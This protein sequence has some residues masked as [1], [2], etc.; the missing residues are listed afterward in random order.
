[1]TPSGIE[2]E[3]FRFVAQHLNHCAT[4]TPR[5]QVLDKTHK[6]Y[7][8]SPLLSATVMAS[9]VSHTRTFIRIDSTCI[10]TYC[11]L[12]CLYCLFVL[13]LLHTFILI[14]FVC[15]SVRT[16]ATEWK[17]NCS[18]STTTTTTT[19]N[20]NNNNNNRVKLCTKNRP[21]ELPALNGRN[22]EELHTI[23]VYLQ[24]CTA[25]CPLGP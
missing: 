20:N 3:T 9:P 10:C 25:A 21:T 11:V 15:T 24:D 7:G 8:H 5:Y 22:I 1:M 2:P 4:P 16:A 14:C 12:Y 13:L 17:L 6:L 18:N 23:S 19:T